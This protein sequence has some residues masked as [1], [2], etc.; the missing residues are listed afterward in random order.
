MRFFP[1]PYRNLI[2][3]TTDSFGGQSYVE[4][5]WAKD[6]KTSEIFN[7]NIIS[8]IS[9]AHHKTPA[10]VILRWCTQRG[11]AVIPKTNSPDRLIENLNCGEFDLT[12]EEINAISALDKGLRFNN[13]ADV[14][15]FKIPSLFF[16]EL[17]VVFYFLVPRR[18]FHLCL[19]LQVRFFYM[20]KVREKRS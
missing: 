7:E 16:G 19:N 8:S 9:S 6:A 15:F 10:Q 13:P 12:E 4:F 17:I 2:Q 11:I 1:S 14:R 3:S 18:P 20:S 5:E